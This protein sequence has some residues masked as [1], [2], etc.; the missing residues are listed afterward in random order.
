[1]ACLSIRRQQV[2]N[3]FLAWMGLASKAILLRLIFYFIG[4]LLTVMFGW[5][6]VSI[7]ISFGLAT[8]AGL[9]H[10]YYRNIYVPLPIFFVRIA[11][12]T[13]VQL[14]IAAMFRHYV[15]AGSIP[16]IA[17]VD[18]VPMAGKQVSDFLHAAPIVTMSIV[19]PCANE[20]RFAWKTAESIAEMTPDSILHEIIVVDD[21]SS[22]PLISQF[23]PDIIEKAKVKFVRHES[24]TGL[25]NAK[26]AGADV[27]TGDIV[28]FLDC[29]VKP[30]P[31][32]A[33][34]IV[35]L[36]RTNYKRVVVPSITGLNPDTWEEERGGGGQAKCYLTWDSD[37]KWFDSDDDY[38]AVMSGGL[39][40]MS[41]QWWLE[42][43]GYDRSMKGWGG[44]NIDQ[45][46]RT[47]LCGGEIVQAKTSFVGHMWRTHD[48]P[49]TAARYTV[50][51]GSV[52]INRYKGA[53]VWMGPWVKKLEQFASFR[54]FILKKPDLS[55]IQSVKD[56]LQCRDFSFFIDKFYK[57]YHWA[58]L[59]P[60]FVFHL[61]DSYSG[62]CLAKTGDDKLHL[63]QCSDTNASQLWHRSNRDGNECCSGY[64]NWNS[65]QCITGG[66]IGTEGHSSVC[67]VG[68]VSND[69]FVQ[70]ANNQLVM[71]KKRGACLGGKVAE[72]PLLQ[73]SKCAEG[74]SEQNF[75]QTIVE[76]DALVV[77]GG[78]AGS[79]FRLEGA[80]RKGVCVAA[81]GGTGGNLGRIEIHDCDEK[82]AIQLFT[83]KPA[84]GKEFR[85]A[86]AG[87]GMDSLCF[88]VGS[89]LGLYPCYFKQGNDNQNVRIVPKNDG[90]TIE[91]KDGNCLTV[92]PVVAANTTKPAIT[93]MGC[94]VDGGV[95]KRGQF[96]E[97]KIVQDSV[98]S[99]VNKD[100]KCL[101]VNKDNQFVLSVDCDVHLF[102]QDPAD[103][104]K[105]LI[106]VPTGLCV[107]GNNGITPVLYTCYSGENSNQQ[108]DLSNSNTILLERTET[109]FDFEP[110]TASPVNVIPCAVA[111][112]QFKWEEYKP[113][114]P[115]ETEIYNA[116]KKRLE[117]PIDV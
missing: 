83:L 97:K 19:L 9:F 74:T 80:S 69:Q 92:P 57:I 42:T 15:S 38:V 45:S 25:I 14:I 7:G 108:V 10:I 68:G 35:E 115:I 116:E 29:H 94:I 65:D 60:K 55:S 63:A 64:R 47:W 110:A 1:M 86:A 113:F 98:F 100:G 13:A 66:W 76:D 99:L 43:G 67:S 111:E 61:R 58:G 84:A 41:R 30:A 88:D 2:L 54:P 33:E 107:D 6:T 28:V 36:I 93:L 40:A 106:H 3:I 96:F 56:R 91:F 50:P 114:V 44:E 95:T 23:P 8:I 70:L 73:I 17:S 39:L 87:S 112:Q 21:G 105:R 5:G 59:L 71:S 27:A 26:S 11:A 32:W 117:A 46:V 109:C 62:L 34:P 85:L 22:P 24:H 18:T 37:F 16:L 90:V 103:A 89:G 78:V 53:A 79:T 101:G 49:E 31:Q 81:L 48:K 77:P 82:S 4:P 51:P 52:T 72:R 12:F 20:G 104:H 75:V 102:K